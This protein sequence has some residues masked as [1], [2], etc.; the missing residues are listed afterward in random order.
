MRVTFHPPARFGSQVEREHVSDD[1]TATALS[2]RRP[3]LCAQGSGDVG[4]PGGGA[5]RHR[6]AGYGQAGAITVTESTPSTLEPARKPQAVGGRY[7]ATSR[8]ASYHGWHRIGAVRAP[9]GHSTRQFVR[10]IVY[11]IQPQIG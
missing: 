5:G 11:H 1:R 9:P 6:A 2:E 4:F 8:G 7:N 3:H 10:H